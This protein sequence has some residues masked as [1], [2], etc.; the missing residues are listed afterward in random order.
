MAKMTFVFNQDWLRVLADYPPEVTA[1]VLQAIR[2]YNDGSELPRM[3]TVAEVCFKFIRTELDHNRAKYEEVVAKR[4]EA[5]RKGARKAAAMAAEAD[6]EDVA[7]VGASPTKGATEAG[8]L[9]RKEFPAQEITAYWNE[10][11]AGRAI[12]QITRISAKTPRYRLLK[13][14]LRDYGLEGLKEAMD[15]TAE[16]SFLNGNN[17]RGFT[18]SFDWLLQPANFL[19]VLEGNYKNTDNDYENRKNP[20][21]SARRRTE[22]SAVGAN[23]FDL[24]L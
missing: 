4:R 21:I 20:D 17:A 14:C 16:S 13:A 1:E 22:P 15:R 8:S 2:L 7:T 3:S 24:A 10:L 11:M 6:C 19:K 12:P 9:S 18:A 23:G 5:G